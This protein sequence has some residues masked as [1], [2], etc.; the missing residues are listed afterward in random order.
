MTPKR[1]GYAAK[2]VRKFLLRHIRGRIH[3]ISQDDLINTMRLQKFMYGEI[4]RREI[5]Y[6]INQLLKANLITQENESGQVY[7][8]I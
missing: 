5:E 2:M 6:G 1:I 4:P 3:K 7:L 8:K